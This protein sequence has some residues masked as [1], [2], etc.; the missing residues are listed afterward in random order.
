MLSRKP[1]DYLLASASFIIFTFIGYG[2]LR[3]QTASL[4]LSY[5]VLFGLYLFVIGQRKTLD[6]AQLNF[7]IIASIVFRA[8][9]LFSVPNLSDDF[10]RFIWDGR[11][12]TAGANPFS[13]IPSYYMNEINSLPGLDR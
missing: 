10:Y 12:L 5:S 2:L 8:S 3:Y 6:E 4:L 9:L 7:W 13:E 11:I 1:S